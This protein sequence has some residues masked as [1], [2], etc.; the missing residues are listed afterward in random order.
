MHTKSWCDH[1]GVLDYTML[2]FIPDW[3]QMYVSIICLFFSISQYRYRHH[4]TFCIGPLHPTTDNR[5]VFCLCIFMVLSVIICSFHYFLDTVLFHHD[6]CDYH[7]D[8]Y[9]YNCYSGSSGSSNAHL[10]GCFRPFTFL[11]ILDWA[12]YLRTPLWFST[13]NLQGSSGLCNC[14]LLWCFVP[15]INHLPPVCWSTFWKSSLKW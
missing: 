12:C 4:V 2:L 11:R 13:R 3:F 15:W 8:I 10:P 1:D 6:R 7:W 5:T 9:G 14:L